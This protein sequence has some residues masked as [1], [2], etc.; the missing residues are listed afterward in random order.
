M[1]KIENILSFDPYITVQ[2]YLDYKKKSRFQ[3]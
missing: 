1:T 2:K 3:A